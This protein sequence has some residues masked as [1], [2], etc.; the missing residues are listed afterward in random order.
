M[1]YTGQRSG[2]GDKIYGAIMTLV[3][4]LRAVRWP[5][6]WVMRVL[7]AVLSAASNLMFC[8]AGLRGH[9]T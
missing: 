2:R 4:A 8:V 7:G 1:G 3:G 5:Y 9:S 6:A